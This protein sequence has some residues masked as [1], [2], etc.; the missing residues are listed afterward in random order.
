MKK[1]FV[2]IVRNSNLESTLI[3]TPTY[4]PGNKFKEVN[5]SLE[6]I[7]STVTN[8]ESSD[9]SLNEL[10][11]QK[12]IER[13]MKKLEKYNKK[14]GKIKTKKKNRIFQSTL[15]GGNYS[16]NKKS[17]IDEKIAST[18]F[19]KSNVMALKMNK[20]FEQ[21]SK[22][23]QLK[24]ILDRFDKK[25]FANKYHP[26]YMNHYITIKRFRHNFDF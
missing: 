5:T 10:E 9:I 21:K 7:L 1:S 12:L 13:K 25:A 20:K 26:K 16:N 11:I 22:Y 4:S 15:I 19:E 8:K 14:L 6:N 24:R 18:I 17:Q 2:K 3:N 23:L